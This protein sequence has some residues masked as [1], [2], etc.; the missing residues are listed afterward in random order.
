MTAWQTLPRGNL[1]RTLHNVITKLPQPA[2]SGL[3]IFL[4]KLRCASIPQLF[5]PSAAARGRPCSPD[6]VFCYRRV[7]EKTSCGVSQ[8]SQLPVP[9]LPQKSRIS[10]YVVK[11][12]QHPFARRAHK[13]KSEA[14]QGITQHRCLFPNNWCYRP[15][16]LTESSVLLVITQGF[17]RHANETLI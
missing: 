2:R 15:S 12:L 13:L 11:L 7:L 1:Q 14:D 6:I 8:T 16:L 5:L 4:D 9:C 3:R 17:V 10:R